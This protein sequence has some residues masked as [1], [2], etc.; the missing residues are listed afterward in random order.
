MRTVDVVE[1]LVED[2]EF[3]ISILTVTDNID[4]TFT[5]TMCKTYHLQPTFSVTIDSVVYKIV[6]VARDSN[7][8]VSGTIEPPVTS[9][10]AYTP[11]FFYGTPN[12]AD[13]ELTH[14]K[15]DANKTPMGYLQGNLRERYLGRDSS[16]EKE[17]EIRLY[18]LTQSNF[19]KWTTTDYHHN[20]I[21]PM[22]ELAMEFIEKAKRSPM[23]NGRQIEN[24]EIN[25]VTKVGIEGKKKFANTDLSGVE[26]VLTLPIVKGACVPCSI[27]I[28][29]SGYTWE[30]FRT[31][32]W[33]DAKIL[34]WENLRN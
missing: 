16:I 25:D 10:T 5:L 27:V 24:W 20:A 18:F 7:I 28:V 2:L 15:V 17:V 11:Y 19:P 14:I 32:T 30:E 23:L 21:D 6:S 22:R 8:V 33:E 9:F 12:Q 31:I 34:T 29:P 4:G 3:T 1:S 13:I 26:L